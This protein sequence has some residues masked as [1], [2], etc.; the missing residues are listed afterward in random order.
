MK[1]GKDMGN[2][3]WESEYQVVILG[4]QLPGGIVA[5]QQ[6]NRHLI[7]LAQGSDGDE[8]RRAIGNALFALGILQAIRTTQISRNWTSKKSFA[9]APT[10]RGF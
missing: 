3:A 6:F 5:A 9:E 2:P 1:P 7:E 8:G 10:K 4:A